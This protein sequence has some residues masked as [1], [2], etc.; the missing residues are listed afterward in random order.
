MA[1]SDHVSSAQFHYP[2]SMAD[3]SSNEQHQFGTAHRAY[4]S[5]DTAL[6]F[7]EGQTTTTPWPRGG[8]SKSG[9]TY[10]R[11]A[12]DKAMQSPPQLDDYDPRKLHAT[13][14]S[15]SRQ[16]VEYYMGDEYK[17]T[18]RTSADQGNVGNQFPTV[19][20]SPN[21]QRL[22]LSGHHRA[23]AALLQGQPLRARGVWPS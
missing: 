2:E 4:G 3:A 17:N 6:L 20:H 16:H 22:L 18:G 5:K 15:L 8:K 14:P 10:D 13:Q 12:V 7:G 23:A 11:G 19:Y 21:G 1:A 9:P